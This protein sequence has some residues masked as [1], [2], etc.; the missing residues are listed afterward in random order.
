MIW[1]LIKSNSEMTDYAINSTHD[2]VSVG[3]RMSLMGVATP[4][5]L[6]HRDKKQEM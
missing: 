2:E 6:T 3:G 1:A 4:R 5:E